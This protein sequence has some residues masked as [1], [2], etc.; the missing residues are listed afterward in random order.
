MKTI[1]CI[2]AVSTLA[3][4]MLGCGS[5]TSGLNGTWTITGV[6]SESKGTLTGNAVFKESGGSVTGTVTCA[7]DTSGFCLQTTPYDVSGAVSGAN[8]ALTVANTCDGAVDNVS[9]TGTIASGGASM[10]GSY[11][12]PAVSGCTT[13]DAGTWTATKD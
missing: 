10:S 4:W 9:L 6:S 12:Q 13:G 11:S 1:F 7:N 8:L 5:R 3:V 2:C